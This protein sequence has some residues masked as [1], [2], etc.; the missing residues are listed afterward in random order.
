MT[1]TPEQADVRTVLKRWQN[2]LSEVQEILRRLIEDPNI[3]KD[4]LA[5]IQRAVILNRL[6]VEAGESARIIASHRLTGQ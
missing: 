2:Q 3:D 5:E 4:S 6:T 1:D